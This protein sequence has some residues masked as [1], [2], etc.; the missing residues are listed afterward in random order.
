MKVLLTIFADDRRIR[1]QEA[2]KY[3]FRSDG[4]V[5]ATLPTRLNTILLQRHLCLQKFVLK[6]QRFKKRCITGAQECVE[7]AA[8]EGLMFVF[9]I[10][11]HRFEK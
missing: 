11:L 8:T 9:W 6:C 7:N 2:R 10:L 3:T 5:S 1:I 4:S